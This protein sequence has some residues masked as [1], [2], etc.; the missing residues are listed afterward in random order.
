MSKLLIKFPSRN[1][2]EKF[3]KVLSKYIDNLSG[4]HDVRFVITMDTDDDT[5]NTEDIRSFLESEN[6]DIV[7]HYGNSKTK[8]EA[9]NANLEDESADVLMLVSDDMIPQMMNYDEVIF[10]AFSQTFPNF[11]GAVKFHDG[12]RQDALMTLAVIGWKIYEKWGYIYHPDYTSVYCDNEQTQVLMSVGKLAV[13]PVCIAKHEWT[14]QPFD[15]LHARN[16]NAE[17][18]QKD[19]EV[20]NRRSKLNFEREQLL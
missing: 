4:N 18:Y 1:R 7:Y 10:D 14:P 6:A 15:D 11:D 5:M 17:M 19:S 20:F 8:I 9:C 2:P 13:S 3:K 12:L 16:E